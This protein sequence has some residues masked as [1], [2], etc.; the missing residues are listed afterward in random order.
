MPVTFV[1]LL[2]PNLEKFSTLLSETHVTRPTNDAA[3]SGSRR[4]SYYYYG[5]D[6]SEAPTMT[7]A[8]TLAPTT[9]AP[10]MTLAPTMSSVPT[11]SPTITSHPTTVIYCYNVRVSEHLCFPGIMR[12]FTCV[13]VYLTRARITLYG[14]LAWAFAPRSSQHPRCS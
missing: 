9:T 12:A 6:V 1:T 7:P 8:P 3:S 4:L 10:T 14:L 11:S 2:F 13:H 5:P